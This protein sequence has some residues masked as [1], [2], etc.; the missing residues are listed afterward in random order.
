M[1]A[2]ALVQPHRPQDHL[3]GH[4]HPHSRLSVY[5]PCKQDSSVEPD[6]YLMRLTRR[7]WRNSTIERVFFISGIFS[8]RPFRR[9]ARLD[10]IYLYFLQDWFS[11]IV[12]DNRR[13]PTLSLLEIGLLEHFVGCMGGSRCNWSGSPQFSARVLDIRVTSKSC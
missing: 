3:L 6:K 7:S 9:C 11:L 4:H 12:R 2:K 5:P 10:S 1:S 8:T 13:N